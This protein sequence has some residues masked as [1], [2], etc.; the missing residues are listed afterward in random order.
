M[1]AFHQQE[2]N[3]SNS[4]CQE[5]PWDQVVPH[6]A[7]GERTAQKAENLLKISPLDAENIALNQMQTIQE[8]SQALQLI[9]H[10]PSAPP[11]AGSQEKLTDSLSQIQEMFLQDLPQNKQE[12]EEL[13][14]W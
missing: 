13:H 7:R 1:I 8:W 5:A 3:D 14:T 2:K 11:S 4:N 6:Y 12:N 10:P 9:L